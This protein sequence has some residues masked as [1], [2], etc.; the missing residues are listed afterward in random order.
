MGSSEPGAVV[1]AAYAALARGDLDGLAARAHPDLA[2]HETGAHVFAGELKGRDQVIE[3]IR[4]GLALLDEFT[5]E[6]TDLV[7]DG[8]RVTALVNWTG[9]AGTESVRIKTVHMHEVRDGL[10]VESF[11]TPIDE[12]AVDE[13]WNRLT[14]EP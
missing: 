1:R 4:A 9:L 6:V 12:S 10:I 13:F 5:I 8:D 2:W 7:E 3:R 14:R 11:L